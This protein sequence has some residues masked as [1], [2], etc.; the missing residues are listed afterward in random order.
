[1]SRLPAGIA[2]I[3]LLATAPAT[4]LN[5]QVTSPDGR[6]EFT[7]SPYLLVPYMKGTTGIGDLQVDVHASPGDIFSHLQFGAML[8]M[9]AN[10][11]TWGVAV[12]GIYM[13]LNQSASAN[14]VSA[15]AGMKQGA[16][17]L[18]GFRRVTGWAE[19]LVG[20]RLNILSAELNTLG[21]Q[22]RSK[23]GDKS[24]FDPIIGARLQVPNTGKW[25]LTL[26]GDVGGFGVGSD[27]AWQVYPK[28]GYRFSKLFELN[29]AYRVISM[30][31]NK[32]DPAFLYDM[33]IFGPEIGLAFHF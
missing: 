29:A 18:T 25:M 31:Y 10:N 15:E 5:A 2:L 20:G 27:L 16:L 11:G 9:E 3:G 28:V 19:V 13:N 22:A 17:E 33:Q 32:G 7:V 23:S 6:W 4:S 24:W 26:R 21:V 8:L 30:D 14:R 12:D 1:V